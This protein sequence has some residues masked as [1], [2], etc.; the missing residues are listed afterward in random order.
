MDLNKA[1]CL[2]HEEYV[3]SVRLRLGCGGPAEPQVCGNCGTAVIGCNGMHALLC[4]RG[5]STRGHNAVRDELHSMAASVDRSAETEPLGLIAS[6][7]Q[8]RPAD[9]LT[10]AFHNGRLA[11]VDVG[12]ICPA[13]SGA[14]LDCVTTMHDRKYERMRPFA[15]ELEAGAIVYRPFAISCW[16]RLHPHATQMLQTLAKRMARRDGTASQRSIFSRLQARITTEIMRRAARMLLRCLPRADYLEGPEAVG[17]E[18]AEQ[19]STDADWRAG[20]PCSI[21]LPAVA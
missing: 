7:P 21:D 19:L 16:G 12:V 4:A 3:A 11:A 15:D 13:A 10:G 14:G 1:K 20:H 8:L 9:I 6:H 5:E 18:G 17:E 2:D